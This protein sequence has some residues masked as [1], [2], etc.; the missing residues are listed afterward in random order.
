MADTTPEMD[1]LLWVLF[2][3]AEPIVR[4]KGRTMLDIIDREVTIT[5]DVEIFD[6]FEAAWYKAEAAIHSTLV[7]AG[8]DPDKLGK[9]MAAF[10]RKMSEKYGYKLPPDGTD[11]G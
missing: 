7:E 2:D 4:N 5:Y 11:N 10:A 9:E 6:A 1:I 8:Y 3:A